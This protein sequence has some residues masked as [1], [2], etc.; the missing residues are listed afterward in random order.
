LQL[1][2]TYD[3]A[4]I[5]PPKLNVTRVGNAEKLSWPAAAGG[6][7]LEGTDEPG[8]DSVWNP[9]PAAIQIL[10]DQFFVT[11]GV[12]EGARFYRLRNVP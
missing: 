6:Y 10:S 9:A 8:A 7:V 4:A 5:I 3:A 11:N 1:V 2:A 12:S